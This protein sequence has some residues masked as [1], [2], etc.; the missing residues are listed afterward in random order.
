[1]N[2][3]GIEKMAKGW[4]TVYTNASTGSKSDFK[5]FDKAIR[6]TQ[7]LSTYE[8]KKQGIELY[9]KKIAE[10]DKLIAAVEAGRATKP[11]QI[12]RANAIKA[13][14]EKAKAKTEKKEKVTASVAD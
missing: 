11:E 10:E 4:K 14:R 7:S 9:E 2:K 13:A 5:A 1:M 6:N 12:E 8:L 3:K